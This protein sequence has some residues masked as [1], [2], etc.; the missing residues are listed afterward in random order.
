MQA[1]KTVVLAAGGQQPLSAA[2]LPVEFV[3]GKVGHRQLIENKA[4]KNQA[5]CVRKGKI[6][7]LKMAM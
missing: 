7:S 2:G 4:R 6:A 1:A 5:R 3:P